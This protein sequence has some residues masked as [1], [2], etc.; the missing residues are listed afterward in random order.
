[1]QLG[2]FLAF[3]GI[4]FGMVRVI[5]RGAGEFASRSRYLE[6]FWGG[7]GLSFSEKRD[8]AGF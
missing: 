3:Q 2:E 7:A 6:N 1:M 5:I 8:S 4:I